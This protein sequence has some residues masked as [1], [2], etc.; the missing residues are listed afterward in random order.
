[1]ENARDIAEELYRSFKSQVLWKDVDFKRIDKFE[2]II[3]KR[4]ILELDKK[5]EEL[6]KTNTDWTVSP[7]AIEI[8]KEASEVKS[9]TDNLVQVDHMT[10]LQRIT[11]AQDEQLDK[12]LSSNIVVDPIEKEITLDNLK[13]VASELKDRRFFITI[14]CSGVVKKPHFQ[15]F[16]DPDILEKDFRTDEVT[17]HLYVYKA[18]VDTHDQRNIYPVIKEIFTNASVYNIQEV[19]I[20]EIPAAYKNFWQNRTKL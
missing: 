4:F 1:M 20:D 5:V 2:K 14:Q 16:K 8:K 13:E 7:E 9:P 3:R 6:E 15:V 11:E 12:E 19:P 17:R 18:F 10:L